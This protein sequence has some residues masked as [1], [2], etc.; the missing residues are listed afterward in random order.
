MSANLFAFLLLLRGDNIVRD[1]VYNIVI[2][3][4]RGYIFTG[5]YLMSDRTIDTTAV[6][7]VRQIGRSLMF[8]TLKPDRIGILRGPI[9]LENTFIQTLRPW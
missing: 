8:L 7:S 1:R 2:G 4:S 9:E 6:V 5:Q 3:P